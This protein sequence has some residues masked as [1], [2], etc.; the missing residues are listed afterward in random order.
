MKRITRLKKLDQIFHS[1]LSELFREIHN[2][3]KIGY[4]QIVKQQQKVLID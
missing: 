3:N 1:T 4:V 2:F